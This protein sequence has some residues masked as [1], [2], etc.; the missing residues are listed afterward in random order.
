MFP[1]NFASRSIQLY[2]IIPRRRLASATP[3]QPVPMMPSVRRL[4]AL[5]GISLASVTGTGPHGRVLKGD[6]LRHVEA[7]ASAPRAAPSPS[8]SLLSSQA[9]SATVRTSPQ[10]SNFKDIQNSNMRQTIAK[11]LLEAKRVMP[12]T[13]VT[14]S[15][16]LE[17]LIALREQYKTLGIAVTMTDLFVKLLAAGLGRVP[18]INVQWDEKSGTIVSRSTVDVA[19]AVAVPGGLITPVLRNVSGKGLAALSMESKSLVER[20]RAG[21]LLPHE[22]SDASIT[23][24]NLGM[25]GIHEF[26]AILNP[27]QAVTVAIGAPQERVQ[28]DVD[29]RPHASRQCTLSVSAD[30]RALDETTV[31]KFLD[32]LRSLANEPSSLLL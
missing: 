12:H 27:P 11:R 13:Y 16:P 30:A 21:T 26:K 28:F 32:A 22:Y 20:A 3:I 31:G 23:L 15:L 29:G 25:F 17:G 8:P 5:H 4:L 19:L 9:A 10:A 14:A 18:E 24:S 6:V 2:N 7:T 1:F